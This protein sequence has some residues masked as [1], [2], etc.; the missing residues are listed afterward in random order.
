MTS[1]RT[2]QTK[3]DRQSKRG[4]TENKRAETHPLLSPTLNRPI[5]GF[6]YAAEE[7][8]NTPPIGW[9]DSACYQR[10]SDAFTSLL[11]GVPV[12]LVTFDGGGAS[13]LITFPIS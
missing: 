1:P 7:D 10:D 12:T 6:K 9:L 11:V 3:D 4:S 2:A 13:N 5:I 8:L